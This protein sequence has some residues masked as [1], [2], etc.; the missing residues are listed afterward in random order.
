MSVV[1]R[2]A[3]CDTKCAKHDSGPCG[4]LVLCWGSGACFTGLLS[5]SCELVCVCV[6]VCVHC[7][8]GLTFAACST[9]QYPL[10]LSVSFRMARF[11][12]R[13]LG[14]SATFRHLKERE[15]KSKE[16]SKIFCQNSLF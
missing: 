14:A 12:F 8:V 6:C 1:A 11:L 5:L 4:M 15:K 7:T 16:E 9:V 2:C 13:C 10:N 3:V